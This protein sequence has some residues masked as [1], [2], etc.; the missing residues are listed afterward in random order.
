MAMIFYSLSKCPICNNA[1]HESEDIIGFPPFVANQLDT[2]Y[3]FNDSGC[4]RQCVVDHPHGR[5]AIGLSEKLIAATRPQNRICIISGALIDH[6][7]NYFCTGLLTSDE[8]ED[9]YKY[10]F[11]TIDKRHIISWSEREEAINELVVFK[12]KNLWTDMSD[13]HYLDSI[14]NELK[15]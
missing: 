13:T 5:K 14:I 12:N 2:L 10:N 15:G 8:Q 3:V 7:A 11:I 9:L 6:P 4:H 1:L